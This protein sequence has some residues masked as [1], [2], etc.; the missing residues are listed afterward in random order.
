[1]NFSEIRMT[2]AQN[3][4]IFKIHMAMPHTDDIFGRAQN[5]KFFQEF[6]TPWPR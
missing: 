2:M 6:I 4:E 5:D 1:M 3:D